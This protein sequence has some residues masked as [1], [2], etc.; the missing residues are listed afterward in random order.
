MNCSDCGRGISENDDNGY[1]TDGTVYCEGC[2]EGATNE[3]RRELNEMYKELKYRM[4]IV[5]DIATL[6]DVDT[7]IEVYIRSAIIEI[8]RVAKEL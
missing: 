2:F 7:N 4:E 6:F 8:D 3:A 5:Q 1:L